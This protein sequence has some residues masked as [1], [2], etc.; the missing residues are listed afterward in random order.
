MS[1]TIYDS[2][3]GLRGADVGFGTAMLLL[4]ALEFVTAFR[5]LKRKKKAP[6][7]LYAH[8]ILSI[9]VML[10]C[11]FVIIDK[12]K[13]PSDPL[14]WLAMLTDSYAGKVSHLITAVMWIMIIAAALSAVMTIL[15]MIYYRKRRHL[16]YN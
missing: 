12:I 10:I 2:F 9:V 4:A 6:Y 11:G 7:L 1:S 15:N 14:A 8:D 5:M 13:M 16:F 3:P